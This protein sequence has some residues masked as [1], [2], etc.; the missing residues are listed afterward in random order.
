MEINMRM[1]EIQN[2][3]I[4]PNPY[5]WTT[6]IDLAFPEVSDSLGTGPA[7]PRSEGQHIGPQLVA[8]LH[9]QVGA[10]HCEN[11]YA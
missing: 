7:H 10:P 6:K 4:Y 11:E 3:I 8:P 5:A 2:L 1:R 9:V